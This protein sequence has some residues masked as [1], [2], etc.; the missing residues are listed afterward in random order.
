M[1]LESCLVTIFQYPSSF[2]KCNNLWIHI[3]ISVNFNSAR[4]E[5]ALA[6]EQ[7]DLSTEEE[8]AEQARGRRAR[9]PPARCAQSSMEESIQDLSDDHQDAS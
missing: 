7:T 8:A 9:P 5:L 4:Q 2:S 1:M 3:Y 6:V